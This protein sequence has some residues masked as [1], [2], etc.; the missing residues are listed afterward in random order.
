MRKKKNNDYKI[1]Y[2]YK[3]SSNNKDFNVILENLFKKYLMKYEK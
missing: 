1:N 2:I 3:D